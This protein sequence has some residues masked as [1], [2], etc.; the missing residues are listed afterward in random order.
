MHH[1][2]SLS[3]PPV[4][5]ITYEILTF[6]RRFLLLSTVA[7]MSNERWWCEVTPAIWIVRFTLGEQL[8][9]GSLYPFDE[10]ARSFETCRNTYPWHS[11]L[12]NTRGSFDSARVMWQDMQAEI[13]EG[14]VWR[15]YKGW[16][17][18]SAAC[19]YWTLPV[20]IQMCSAACLLPAAIQMCSAA[21][22]YWTLS[23]TIQMCSAAFPYWTLSVTI[24]MYFY[25]LWFHTAVWIL[26]IWL[27]Y[28]PP[29]LF[30]YSANK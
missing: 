13:I 8:Q 21:C 3:A 11:Q 14:Y 27:Y 16:Q 19:P 28:R 20:A 10:G 18:C 22:P 7:L 4:T 29:Q 12:L 25:I 6:V 15:L 9:P 26:I 30:I 17:M 1:T 5:A 2:N 23:V 24:Q